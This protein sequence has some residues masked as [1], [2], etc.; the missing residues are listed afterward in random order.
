[1]Q[2]DKIPDRQNISPHPITYQNET[3]LYEATVVVSLLIDL[4]EYQLD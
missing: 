3:A 1:M 4:N 2:V